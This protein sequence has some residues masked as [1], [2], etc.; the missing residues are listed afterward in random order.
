MTLAAG[1]ARL[2][3]ESRA[4][5]AARSIMAAGTSGVSRAKTS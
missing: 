1:V 4:H 2:G 3:T 5:L